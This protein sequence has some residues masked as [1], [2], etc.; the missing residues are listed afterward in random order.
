MLA[1]YVEPCDMQ[2]S[3]IQGLTTTIYKWQVLVKQM[4]RVF[5]TTQKIQNANAQAIST[6]TTMPSRF[7]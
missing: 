3:F 1:G 4:E 7:S 5:I 6:D 2:S